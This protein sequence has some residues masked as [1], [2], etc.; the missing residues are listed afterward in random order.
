MALSWPSINSC[1]LSLFFRKILVK[2]TMQPENILQFYQVCK[3]MDFEQFLQTSNV[4]IPV[5]RFTL[6]WRLYILNQGQ[7]Q[8][9]CD[10]LIHQLDQINDEW[11]ELEESSFVTVNTFMACAVTESLSAFRTTT[12]ELWKLHSA[13]I[14]IHLI[15]NSNLPIPLYRAN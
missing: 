9:G 13:T 10:K 11:V 1:L 12:S 6:D 4:H 2:T 3:E 8:R 5:L 7:C 15:C 14:P